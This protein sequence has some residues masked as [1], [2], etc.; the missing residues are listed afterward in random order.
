LFSWSQT[1]EAQKLLREEELT[2]AEAKA[3]SHE[4]EIQDMVKRLQVTMLVLQ[5]FVRVTH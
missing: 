4:R 3:A 1:I 5:R 2:A